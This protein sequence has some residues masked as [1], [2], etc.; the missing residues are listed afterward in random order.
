MSDTKYI[1]KY[2]NENAYNSDASARATLG[3][4]TVSMEADTRKLHFD[5]VN[6]EVP[7]KSVRV[8]TAVYADGNGNLHFVDGATVKSASIPSGWEFVGVV[9]LRKGGKALVLHK[10]ENTGIRFTSCWAWEITGVVYGSSN[11][12]QFQQRKSTGTNTFAMV[13]IGSALVFTPTDIDEAVSKIDT[14][15]KASGNAGG[16][17]YDSD[18]V[19]NYNWHC[20]KLDGRIWV[21]ADFDSSPSYRQYEVGVVKNTA[22]A[23]GPVSNNNM[24]TLAGMDSNYVTIRRNDGVNS[25]Y[26]SIWNKDVVRVKA[27]NQGSPVDQVAHDGYYSETNFNNTSVLKAYYGTYDKYLDDLMPKYP[28]NGGAMKAYAGKGAKTCAIAE[29]V[30]YTK[31]DGVTTD[32]MF[33]AIH[34]AKTLKAHSTASVDGMNAGDWYMPGLDE[35]VDIFSQMKVDGSDPIHQAFANAGM[36]SAY[37]INPSS[38][39]YRWVPAR[40][41]ANYIAWFLNS[42]GNVNGNAFSNYYRACGVALLAL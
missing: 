21:I 33:T 39:V 11:T 2:E 36:S 42:T 38:N 24:W 15:L 7:R 28:V 32:Y 37:P 9:S 25:S 40:F 13:D 18:I 4:S 41:N 30:V 5:G 27:S 23:N 17:S 22:V 16:K 14:H 35:I 3:K 19:A 8:G 20:E 1:N 26:Y 34:Y 29:S 12:I 10:N 6:V 31:R